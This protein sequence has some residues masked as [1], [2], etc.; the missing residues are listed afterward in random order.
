M[1]LQEILDDVEEG[2]LKNILR[3]YDSLLCSVNFLEE[4]SVYFAI[5][6]VL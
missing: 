5:F 3:N 6:G 2:V 1:I 4:F